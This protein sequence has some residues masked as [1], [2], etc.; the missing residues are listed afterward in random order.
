MRRTRE[1]SRDIPRLYL[2]SGGECEQDGGE[3][4][5]RQLKHLPPARACMVQIREKRLGAEGLLALSVAAAKIPLPEGSLLLVNGH[6]D[7]AFAA[8]LDGVH[9]PEIA[10]VSGQS[11][12]FPSDLIVGC[13]AHSGAS[14]RMAQAAG[15][16]FLLFGP[17]FDTPSKRQY[18][19]A[20]GL[21]RLAEICQ[22]TRLPVFA[23]GG[24]TPENAPDC[25]AAGAHGIA[26]VSAFRD[27]ERLAE[28]V[29]RF[30]RVLPG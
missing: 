5:L 24:L 2:I 7:I 11:T 16:D 27:G 23:V 8:G 9:W 30:F 26:G 29:E 10:Y 22:S 19:P 25:L 28:I 4:L 1:L 21:A 15:A 3:S 18:G 20:Q 13:S 14:A 12:A 6:A 17:I